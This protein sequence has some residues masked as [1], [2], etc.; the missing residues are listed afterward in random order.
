MERTARHI[1]VATDLSPSTGPLFA[2]ASSLVHPGAEVIGLHVYTP[3]DYVDVQRETGMPIDQYLANIRAEM[4]FQA[5]QAGIPPASIRFEIVEGWSVPEQILSAATRFGAA[6]IVMATHGRTGLR[7]V[8]MG[9]VAEEV[10]RRAGTPVLIVP[11]AALDALRT[12]EGVQ[13]A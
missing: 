13:A 2:V 11:M 10:L 6:L 8:L 12:R 7:R 4:R 9:S 5:D 1:L 3:E